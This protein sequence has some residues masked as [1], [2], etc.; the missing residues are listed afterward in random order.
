[1]VWSERLTNLFHLH[2]DG[3]S[4]SAGRGQSAR[5]AV[6]CGRIE[7]TLG[8][9]H[10]RVPDL[11]RHAITPAMPNPTN[12]RV[13]GSGTTGT[14]STGGCSGIPGPFGM[15]G[16][17]GVIFIPGIPVKGGNPGVSPGI[18]SDG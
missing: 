18:R 3:R 15:S 17:F 2:D 6:S 13:A 9:R 7:S 5:P 12:T 14:G 10:D 1:M 11:R 8:G 16:E 4:R